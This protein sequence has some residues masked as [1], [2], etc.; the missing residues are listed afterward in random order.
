MSGVREARRIADC[1][2]SGGFFGRQADVMLSTPASIKQPPQ[3]QPTPLPP[4]EFTDTPADE[5]NVTEAVAFDMGGKLV[6]LALPGRHVETVQVH[7]DK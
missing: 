5:L 1:L 6:T 4:S 2:L 3:P 7:S